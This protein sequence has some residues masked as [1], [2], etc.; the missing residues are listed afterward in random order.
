MIEVKRK[1]LII[2][3]LFVTAGIACIISIYLT[4][5]DIF[6]S[7]N[8]KSNQDLSILK[9]RQNS[10][11]PSVKDNSLKVEQVTNGLSIPTSMAFIDNINILILE[12][13]TGHV[14]LI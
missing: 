1:K 10:L 8:L 3:V 6:F 14:R 12:K 5:S 9:H 11:L 7:A 13:N 2:L 4:K